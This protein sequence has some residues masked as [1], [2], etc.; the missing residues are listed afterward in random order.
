M[1]DHINISLNFNMYY[2]SF[3]FICYWYVFGMLFNIPLIYLN[4]KRG[5]YRDYSV[6]T[7]RG[8]YLWLSSFL[9]FII[10]PIVWPLVAFNINELYKKMKKRNLL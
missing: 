10:A 8:L 6:K 7:N 3:A 4:K 9:A 1:I 5:L 2:P